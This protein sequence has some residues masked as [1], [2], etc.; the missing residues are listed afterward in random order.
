MDCLEKKRGFKM[1]SFIIFSI[2]FVL[3]L[4]LLGILFISYKVLFKEIKE[5]ETK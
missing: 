3:F 1:N 5:D 4:I 2:L